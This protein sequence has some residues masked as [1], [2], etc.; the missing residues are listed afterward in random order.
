ML[1]P[2]LDRL[3]RTADEDALEEG[4]D[5]EAAADRESVRA[6]AEP[7]TFVWGVLGGI[8]ATAVMTA[9][10]LPIS[11]SLPPTATFWAKF[12]GSGEPED[13]PLLGLH[14]HLLYGAGGGAAF[15][16]LEERLPTPDGWSPEGATT[17]WGLCYGIVLSLFGER[18]IVETLLGQD[19]ADHE[20]VVFHVGHVVYGLTL[21]SWVGSRAE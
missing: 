13:Y 8:V 7:D 18:V 2:I 11:R 5:L 20:R 1:V 21:G 14:L 3:Q 9:Y 19:L 4:V 17:L 12:V 15:A 6:L 10:R 16:V